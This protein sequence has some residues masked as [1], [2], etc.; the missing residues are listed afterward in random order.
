VIA[1]PPPYDGRMSRGWVWAAYILF[2]LCLVGCVAWPL[3]SDSD[4]WA[5]GFGALAVL[6]ISPVVLGPAIRA[7]ASTFDADEPPRGG[8]SAR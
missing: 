7:V 3:W 8:T 6:V 2:S 1:A 4:V 5:L